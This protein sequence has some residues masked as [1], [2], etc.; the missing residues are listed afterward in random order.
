[1]RCHASALGSH[2]LTHSTGLASKNWA[3]SRRT[4]PLPSAAGAPAPV[5]QTPASNPARTSGSDAAMAVRHRAASIV[6]VSLGTSIA[7]SPRA[8]AHCVRAAVQSTA[9]RNC[10]LAGFRTERGRPDLG[11]LRHDAVLPAPSP[12]EFRRR[13]DTLV[14]QNF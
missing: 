10:C 2:A 11:P 13:G 1:M 7:S 3:S 4:C 9:C 12:S 6:P 5:A 14:I 8:R